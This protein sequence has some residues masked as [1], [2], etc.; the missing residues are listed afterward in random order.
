MMA[1]IALAVVFF[2]IGISQPTIADDMRAAVMEA[3]PGGSEEC[4]LSAML[5]VRD[6]YDL[7][8]DR[9]PVDYDSRNWS[10]RWKVE[11]A[12]RIVADAEW[13]PPECATGRP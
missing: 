4:H 5:G 13:Q 8:S 7:M 12:V 3:Y 10:D 2:C 1:P 9:Q 11:L 6:A